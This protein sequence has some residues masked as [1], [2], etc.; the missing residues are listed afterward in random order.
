M[1]LVQDTLTVLCNQFPLVSALNN[2][3]IQCARLRIDQ[4]VPTSKFNLNT[5][6]QIY[7]FFVIDPSSNISPVNI[8]IDFNSLPGV[9]TSINEIRLGV[10]VA[11]VNFTINNQ[12]TEYT[13]YEI[14]IFHWQNFT[15]TSY[16]LV[17][18]IKFDSDEYRTDTSL[19]KWNSNIWNRLFNTNTSNNV[20]YAYFLKTTNVQL[21]F[22]II[23][24]SNIS[25]LLLP[26]SCYSN[27]LYCVPYKLGVN[28]LI[29]LV[30]SSVLFITTLI[31]VAVLHYFKGGDDNRARHFER[32]YHHHRRYAQDRSNAKKVRHRTSA[33]ISSVEPG[34]EHI[35]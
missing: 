33:S 1:C 4:N 31:V 14:P 13:S 12:T 21:D 32:Y 8:I 11:D 6:T 29:L 30:C 35:T 15:E 34:D 9:T 27:I 26:P 3:D 28:E 10:L 17:D 18:L 7:L 25:S 16:D 2:S 5:P 24:P 19:C 22:T 20:S 23:D